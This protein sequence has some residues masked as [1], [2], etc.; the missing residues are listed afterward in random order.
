[1]VTPENVAGL[2]GGRLG[3]IVLKPLTAKAGASGNS[4]IDVT[5]LELI[6]V[7]VKA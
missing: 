5:E 1:M 7:E 2:S 4:A 6:R 3:K